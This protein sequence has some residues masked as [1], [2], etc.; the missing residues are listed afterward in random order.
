MNLSVA[1]YATLI[2][3]VH[4][5]CQHLPLRWLISAG[6]SEQPQAQDL[7]EQLAK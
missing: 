1:Q 6:P 4:Q 3:Q 2:T 7:R 5:Q